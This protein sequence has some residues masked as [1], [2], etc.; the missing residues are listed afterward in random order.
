MLLLLGRRGAQSLCSCGEEHGQVWAELQAV[1]QPCS[2]ALLQEN[3]QSTPG[4]TAST[5][6]G[7]PLFFRGY[8]PAGRPG[9]R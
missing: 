6:R 9:G 5:Q 4:F 8:K 2:L 1:Q 7:Y 3:L